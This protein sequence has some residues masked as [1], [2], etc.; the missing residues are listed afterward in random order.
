MRRVDFA[1]VR[2]QLRDKLTECYRNATHAS[3]YTIYMILETYLNR[4][5][6]IYMHIHSTIQEFKASICLGCGE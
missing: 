1:R 6:C 3:N 2:M 5:A 4:K